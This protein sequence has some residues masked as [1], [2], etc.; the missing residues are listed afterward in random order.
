MDETYA[1]QIATWKARRLADLKADAGWLNLTDRL[2]VT[3]GRWRV[4]RAA[5]NDLVLSVGPEHLGLLDLPV[6]GA[7][8]ILPEGTGT[9]L[10]FQPVPDAYPQVRTEGLILEL[11]TL[12][13]TW[14]LRVRDCDPA[15]RANFPGLAYFPLDPTWRV[16]ARWEPLATPRT[17][18]I[19]MVNGV[20]THVTLTHR[21]SF[22]RDGKTWSLLPTHLKS[23]KPMFVLRD[24]TSKSETYAASRFLYGE[25]AGNGTIVLDF[26][27]AFNPPCAFTDLAVCPLPP[28]ENILPFRIEAGELMPIT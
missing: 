9:A 13:G 1:E 12:E 10:P 24:L 4:G 27:K 14:A 28:Q 22:E 17:F 7:A 21:A 18:D 3:P 6:D 23:G 8:T 11:T 25:E 2:E 16:L 15:N 20:A 26:N 19:D 5:D